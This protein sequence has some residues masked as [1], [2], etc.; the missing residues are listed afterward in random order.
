MEQLLWRLENGE[1]P[2]RP[3]PQG[4]RHNDRHQWCGL[5]LSVPP[6]Q[7]V[8]VLMVCWALA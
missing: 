7:G 3:A 8:H 1:L 2:A 4:C 6:A 5:D